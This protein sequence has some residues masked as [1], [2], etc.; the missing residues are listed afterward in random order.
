MEKLVYRVNL[1]A[2]IGTSKQTM[3]FK[4]LVMPFLSELTF[5]D[6]DISTDDWGTTSDSGIAT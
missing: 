3:E 1:T 6:L 4:F 5:N 2:T